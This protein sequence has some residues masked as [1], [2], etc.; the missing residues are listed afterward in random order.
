VV[1]SLGHSDQFE[2][3]KIGDKMNIAEAAQ[4]LIRVATGEP[5]G[6][7]CTV[8]DL[9]V[10]IVEPGYGTAETVW[11]SGDWNNRRR[12]VNGERIETST[13]PERLATALE[14]IGVE[15][16][17]HDE[18]TTCDDCRKA[19]RTRGDSYHWTAYYVDNDEGTT[20]LECFASM[21]ETDDGL[22]QF[23]FV[24]NPRRAL[25]D[26]ISES[27][28]GTWGWQRYNGLYENGWH[29]GMNDDPQAIFKQIRDEMPSVDVVFSIYENSQFYL[30]FT[31]W[32]KVREE[33]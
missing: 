23:G 19:V 6:D 8:V 9:G 1:G 16:L 33:D 20:C 10:G 7:G 18:W 21:Y 26:H 11:V 5:Y 27:Q 22:T 32:T 25:P 15:I 29:E 30:R 14:R 31:A 12:Y 17:W 13:V 28:L 24:N 3:N 4:R 2:Y